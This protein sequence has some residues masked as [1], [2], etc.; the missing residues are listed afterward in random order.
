MKIYI[1]GKISGLP[2]EQVTHKFNSAEERLNKHGI[3]KVVNPI[4]LDHSAN[5]EQDW[6]IYMKTDLK[7]LLD[8]D[9]ILMLPCWRDSVGAKMELQTALTLNYNVIWATE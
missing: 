3:K 8:C 5:T 6:V 4:K 7:A 9:T 1:S 2:F